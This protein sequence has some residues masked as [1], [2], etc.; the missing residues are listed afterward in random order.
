MPKGRGSNERRRSYRQKHPKDTSVATAGGYR[1][2]E[3]LYE[4]ATSVAKKRRKKTKEK[5]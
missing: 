3:A 4:Q 2:L 5:V 1:K